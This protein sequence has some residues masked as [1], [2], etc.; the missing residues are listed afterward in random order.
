MVGLEV[1]ILIGI[2][3]GAE[4]AF[5]EFW[6]N[7]FSSMKRVTHYWVG[8]WL[9]VLACPFAHGAFINFETAPVHPVAVS[10][11]DR[12]LAVCNLPDNRVEFFDL[13]S[14]TPRAAGSLFVGMDPVS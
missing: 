3:G 14:G 10:S 9:G 1:A 13:D 4:F 7:L 6:G 8:I 11:D 5:G 2:E 12:M